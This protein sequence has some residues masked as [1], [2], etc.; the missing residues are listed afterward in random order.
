MKS[1]LMPC[2]LPVT[3]SGYKGHPGLYYL[4]E[5]ALLGFPTNQRLK[6]LF[7]TAAALLFGLF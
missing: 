5:A 3:S 2:H 4:T 1:Y 6:T 7:F